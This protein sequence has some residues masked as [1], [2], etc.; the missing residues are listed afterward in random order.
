[1]IT[2]FEFLG[3]FCIGWFASFVL[4]LAFKNEYPKQDEPFEKQ[5]NKS[6]RNLTFRFGLIVAV[7][8]LLYHWT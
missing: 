2:A 5:I 8:W 7:A 3:M 4:L 6:L 1:M